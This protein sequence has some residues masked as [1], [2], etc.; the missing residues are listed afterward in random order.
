MKNLG[1][2]KLL[3][4][5]SCVLITTQIEAQ[6]STNNCGCVQN[7]DMAKSFEQKLLAANFVNKFVR[8]V[9]Q[10]YGT[11][12]KGELKLKNGCTVTN[13]YLRY[14]RYHDELL[15]LRGNDYS[16]GVVQKDLVE[17]FTIFATENQ[18]TMTFRNMRRNKWLLSDSSSMYMQVLADGP[19]L[20]VARRKALRIGENPELNPKDEYF[21]IKD[22]IFYKISIT[23]RSL[24]KFMA[25]EKEAMREIVRENN[26]NLR[27]EAQFAKAI[28]L[29]NQRKP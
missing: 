7:A 5:I 16:I 20:L 28:M 18:P 17:S 15:W 8:S 12:A 19:L 14:N 11:W 27:N 26:L 22:N 3:F 21:F 13:E 2:I 10:F 23:R 4:V 24:Y 1:Y 9:N 6:S 25:T 29:Y